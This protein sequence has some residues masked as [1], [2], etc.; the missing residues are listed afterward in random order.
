MYITETRAT[1]EEARDTDKKRGVRA[2]ALRAVREF[3]NSRSFYVLQVLIACFFVL[4][5]Q[6]VL[7]AICFVALIAAILAVCDD[8][9]A[10]TL[11][12]L[13]ICMMGSDVTYHA[14]QL[15]VHRFTVLYAG[16]LVY[17]FFLTFILFIMSG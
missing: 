5:K 14:L 13:I 9:R 3:L 16:Y 4:I 15:Y 7:G 6:E 12:F 1:E 10:T 11:P 17:C 2:G 8:I